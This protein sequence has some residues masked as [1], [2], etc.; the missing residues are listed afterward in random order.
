MQKRL[1]A[2]LFCLALGSAGAAPA[3]DLGTHQKA[4]GDRLAVLFTPHKGRI[5]LPGG[6]A[7]L[8]LPA[9][10]RYLDSADA[11]RLLEAWGNPP[12]ARSLGML[13]PAGVN[14]MAADSWGVVIT[15]DKNG[16]VR[17]KDAD[18]IDYTKLLKEMQED[19]EDGNAE[20]NKQGSRAM[21]LLG[22]AEPPH[23]DKA[24]RKL[25]WAKELQ[26]EG[27]DRHGLNYNI[28]VLGREGVLVLNAV[29]GIEQLD[30]VRAG[31]QQVTAF[32]RF[33]AG[34]RHADVDGSSGSSSSSSDKAAQYGI[35]ALVAGG[36]AGS[37]LRK[38][39]KRCSS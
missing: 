1:F 7:T 19:L 12:G 23:Y 32:T 5:A 3:D 2:V 38:F 31:M 18:G 24:G 15:Y 9:N 25:Y 10:F 20:R 4:A 28:R 13:V 39:F 26:S 33:T 14:P 37:A 6:I 21:R 16:H 8:D 34:N 11:A 22:W 30:Q 35:A 17:D 29:A 27:D 36:V